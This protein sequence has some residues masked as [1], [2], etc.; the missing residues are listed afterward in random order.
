M[1][2]HLLSE[3]SGTLKGLRKRTAVNK[4]IASDG[5]EINALG[6]SVEQSC[7]ASP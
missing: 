3:A 1:N 6:K 4:E 2:V 5:A 7:F